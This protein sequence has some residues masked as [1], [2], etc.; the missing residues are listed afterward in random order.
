MAH[1]HSPSASPATVTVAI[2]GVLREYC[3]GVTELSLPAANVREVLEAME[4]RHPA[5]HRHLC[6]ETG[7]V[8][9]HINVFVN[10]DHI[11]ELDGL[12]TELSS[13]DVVTLLPAV[14]GG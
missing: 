10:A 2:P 3:G 11:R 14:S 12:D 5:L 6:D 7:A 4:A 13:R 9:R 8:R 1:E